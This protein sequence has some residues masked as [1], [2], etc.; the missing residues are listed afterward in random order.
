MN[1][2]D[3][4]GYLILI[5]G[6]LALFGL[7]EFTLIFFSNR[8]AANHS[9]RFK[10]RFSLIMDDMPTAEKSWIK[11]GAYAQNPAL[12]E[13]LKQFPR[14]EAL[15]LLIGRSGKKMTV[16]QMLGYMGVSGIL[17]LGLGWGL[18]L[19]FLALFLGGAGVFAPLALLRHWVH[20]RSTKIEEQLPDA[21]DMLAQSLRAGHAF[22]G[23]F[24]VVGQQSPEPIG[25][26][27]RMTSDEVTYGSSIREAVLGLAQR[28]ELM[29]V[30][31]F[32]LT[33]LIQLD[34]GGSL[35]NLLQELAK[36]M[37]ERQKLRR[38]I[39]VLSAEGRVSAWILCLLPVA[40]G[41]L[42]TVMSPDY[43][44]YF[45]KEPTGRQ[46]VKG[47][48]GLFVLGILWMKSVTTIKV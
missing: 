15:Y 23:A 13:K 11:K 43:L 21:L 46:L 47:M 19:G 10:M 14:L 32:V 29:D 41:L 36:L 30:R 33:V 45:W 27:F 20:A 31:Y 1:N 34:T 35:S 38:T 37:R 9:K 5:M 16:A 28:V 6:F 12:D 4:W 44:S 2:L 24:R 48:A 42:M 39:R 3:F 18:G 22:S 7:V 40:F 8:S 25:S 26:E 17:G